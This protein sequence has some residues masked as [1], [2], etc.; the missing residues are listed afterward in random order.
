MAQ[1]NTVVSPS[2][3]NADTPQRADLFA[4]QKSLRIAALAD[5]KSRC[6]KR[7]KARFAA[8]LAAVLLCGLAPGL[9][10]TQTATAAAASIN[11]ATT[12]ASAQAQAG[13][14]TTP[15]PNTQSTVP[16]PTAS[17]TISADPVWF[18]ADGSPHP[19]VAGALQVLA[20]ADTH[21]LNPETYE[22][23]TLIE[24]FARLAQ[25]DAPMATQQQRTELNARLNQNLVQYLSDL[26]DGRVDPHRVHQKFDVPP[27]PAFD[28]RQ[29]L[30]SALQ[31]NTV[32]KALHDARPRVPMY[33]AVVKAMAQYRQLQNNPAWA[34]PLPALPGRKL[35]VGQ[36]WAGA[37]QLA[38]RLILLGDIPAHI[39]PSGDTPAG[40][41][42][43]T[44]APQAISNASASS[45]LSG[46]GT[47]TTMS[48]TPAVYDATLEAGVKAF[49]K[50]HG[51][52]EDGIIGPA[53]LAQLN[54]TPAQR[55]KQ[56]ALTLERLRWTPLVSA[57]RM[58]VVNIPEFM[59]RAYDVMPD[60]N[61]DISLHM[62][63]IV[64]RAL[65]TSTPL[66]DEDMRFIEFSPYW[67]IP[68]SIARGETLPRLRRDPAYFDRQGFEFVM[69]DG[70]VSTQLTPA[71]LEAVQ[72]GAARIRQRPGPQ[73]A[74]GDIKFIFPNNTNIYL[75][76]TPSPQLFE[77]SRRDF[78]HGC[79]RVEAPVALAQ[80]V[81]KNEPQ[82]TQ[83]RIEAAMTAG[84]SQTIRLAAPIPVVL[85]YAT[86]VVLE[87]TVYFYDDIYGHDK[88]LAKA[89]K[90]M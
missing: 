80:F 42:A 19:Q 48:N 79:I 61:I 14:A 45:A 60:G 59:L 4:G 71:N 15:G 68:P 86:V 56:M 13:Q 44:Q 38:Q 31:N 37:T 53:T 83:S 65:D 58:I 18:M 20:A 52:T 41:I 62:R 35:E 82:W 49:Q 33:D 87:D 55:V 1:F 26:R 32:A 34:S 7:P 81:L 40:N 69:K 73:N 51:L 6:F 27:K 74:L 47:T 24:Q 54:V 90:M 25:P 57:P 85:A 64:G 30:F 70:S 11:P 36:P 88:T 21:G 22:A 84:K 75:H 39:A 2:A 8:R 12:P 66:F 46:S 9:G 23:T 89:L 78:S 10:S 29:Y 17:L 16:A 50:R 76:H 67:N 28:A 43:A 77:R 5:Q 63:V 3:T 72:K